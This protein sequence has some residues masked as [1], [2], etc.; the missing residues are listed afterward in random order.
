MVQYASNTQVPSERSRG[1]IER[2]LTRYGASAFAYAW[3]ERQAVI[4][5]QA[6]GRQIRFHLPL[7]DRDSREFTH[8]PARGKRRT[9]GAQADAYDQGV[10]ARWRALAL[11]IKAKFAAIDAGIVSFEDEFLAHTVIEGG[12]TVSEW[13]QPQIQR[14]VESGQMP[15]LDPFPD[16][17]RAIEAEIVE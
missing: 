9:V 16:G 5:F 4:A 1:E 2:T 3:Y 10:R 6:R 12:A 8:T 14:A 15:E 13:I 7:P 17:M 11:A